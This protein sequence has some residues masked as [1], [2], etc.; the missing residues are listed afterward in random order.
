MFKTHNKYVA[1]EPF[2]ATSTANV[3]SKGGLL[4]PELKVGLTK[5]KVVFD[6][7]LVKAGDSV[8]VRS[9]WA[10]QDAA[11]TVFK[12]EDKTF[13]LIPESWVLVSC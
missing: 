11:K 6:S 13:I 9:E 2:P 1:V 8:Y 12:V 7:D 5:L 10:F 3:V 4:V